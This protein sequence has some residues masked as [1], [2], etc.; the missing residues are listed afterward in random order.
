M[1]NVVAK[2]PTVPNS[3]SC[4]VFSTIQ[5]PSLV[6]RLPSRGD[7]LI[8]T[9]SFPAQWRVCRAASG[10]SC[11]ALLELTRWSSLSL[12]ASMP[13]LSCWF[14]IPLTSADLLPFSAALYDIA[15][16]RYSLFKMKR[17]W[18]FFAAGVLRATYLDRP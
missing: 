3:A 16:G 14:L 1:D 8:V 17:R 7:P 10:M 4:P 9:Q 13:G 6:S 5:P 18:A 2:H 11:Q 15:S 12:C